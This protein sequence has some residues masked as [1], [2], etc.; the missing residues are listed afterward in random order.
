[1]RPYEIPII[2]DASLEE[3][4]IR[5]VLDRVSKA[6]ESNGGKT[7]RLERWG[8]RRFAYELAHKWEGYYVLLEASAP[9]EA[10]AEAHRILS[11]AD[12][13]LRHK[14]IRL[15]EGLTRRSRP[16]GPSQSER[17]Q[18][19]SQGNGAGHER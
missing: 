15:P 19:S 12:Q 2:F 9:P 11:L 18:V 6:I 16:G 8:R 5:M 13:V 17:S 7:G 3:E 14:V 10:M 1:M 4:A